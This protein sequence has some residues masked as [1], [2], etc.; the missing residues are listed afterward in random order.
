M[1]QLLIKIND[2]VS[3]FNYEYH[4]PASVLIGKIAAANNISPVSVKLTDL[5]GNIVDPSVPV[6]LKSRP[7]MLLASI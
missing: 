4:E 7:N 1:T 2:S 5:S 3:V 6:L